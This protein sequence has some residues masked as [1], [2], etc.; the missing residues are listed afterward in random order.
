VP[1]NAIIMEVPPKFIAIWNKWKEFYVD[2]EFRIPQ[3][4]R[5]DGGIV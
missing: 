3:P 5:V 2:V 1:E 4:Q